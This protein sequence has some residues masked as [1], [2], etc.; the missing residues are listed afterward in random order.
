[1]ENYT[2]AF[3][4]QKMIFNI[5]EIEINTI[6]GKAHYIT[7]DGAKGLWFGECGVWALGDPDDRYFV[8]R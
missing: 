7:D 5:Y 3:Q 1:M 6:N 2:N 8:L 4:A